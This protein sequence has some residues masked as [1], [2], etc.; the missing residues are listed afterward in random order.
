[1]SD[2]NAVTFVRAIKTSPTQVYRAFT[3][4]AALREWLSDG[5]TTEIEIGK[6][7]ILWWND[8]YI[9]AGHFTKLEPDKKVGFTW[10]GAEEPAETQVTVNISAEGDG[11]RLEV[12]HSGLGDGGSWET[13]RQKFQSSWESSLEN[14]VSVLETGK[15]L[16][17][18]SR[19]MLGILLTDFNAEIAARMGVPVSEAIR[20][21]GTLE[22]MGARTAGLEKDDVLVGMAGKTVTDFDSLREA[23]AGKHAGDVVEVNFYRGPEKHAVQMKLSGRPEPT[24]TWNIEELADQAQAVY[25]EMNQK[26]DAALAGVSEAEA[27]A[28]PETEEWSVKEVLCHLISTE[29]YN[30]LFV[31][32][33]FAGSESWTDNN[34][35]GNLQHPIEATLEVFPTLNSLV[36]ELKRCEAETVALIRNLPEEFLERKGSYWRLAEAVQYFPLHVNTHTAQIHEAITAARS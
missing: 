26:L 1:M 22:G 5:A 36:D 24:L 14:L 23:L 21:D 33:L 8:G 12:V 7:I 16:R 13:T 30:M 35:P 27:S 20:I 11:S 17:I 10:K 19:P 18:Y 31:T 34:Y 32:E 15:D 2:H 28:K 9:S 29:R 3:N 6:R 25:A 4:A